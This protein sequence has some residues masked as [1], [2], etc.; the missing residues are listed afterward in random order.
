MIQTDRQPPRPR[1][2]T[3]RRLLKAAAAGGAALCLGLPLYAWRIE[4]HW[5]EVV[6]RDLPLAGLPRRWRGR[7]LVHIAD[8]HVGPIVD[9]DYIRDAMQRVNDLKPDAIVITG[10]LLTGQTPAEVRN[11]AAVIARLHQP[12]LGTHACL[13]NHD[14]GHSFRDARVAAS[15]ADAVGDVGLNVLRN[16]VVD[17]AGLQI[18]GVED[19]WSGRCDIA[20]TVARID[21]ARPAV[22][23]IHNPDG[24]DDPAW[25][26]FRGWV[27]SGHTHGGQVDPPFI[28]P[29]ILPVS[30]VR[31]AAGPFTLAPGRRLYV[32]R[33]LGYL[34]RVRFACRPEITRFR[35][36]AA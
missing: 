20:A 11:A 31:Y 21:P 29:P 36:T 34:R 16:D 22:A 18:A 28:D 27:L 4:P 33:G 9:P 10:D 7:T 25:N 23:L 24:A 13:G 15:L 30:N 6:D 12:P 35:L 19:L 17:V 3:R 32:N 8:L 14:Y 1:R 2:L 26:P 5:I